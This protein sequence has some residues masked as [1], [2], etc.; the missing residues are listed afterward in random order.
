M[1]IYVNTFLYFYK[2]IHP[3]HEQIRKILGKTVNEIESEKR[4]LAKE[5]K[6]CPCLQLKDFSTKFKWKV[7]FMNYFFFFLFLHIYENNCKS[8]N[9]KN[10]RVIP[11]AVAF[12]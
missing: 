3:G 1:T 8:S 2:Q 4:W 9:I 10:R 11:S 12:F 6:I 7:F 5:S